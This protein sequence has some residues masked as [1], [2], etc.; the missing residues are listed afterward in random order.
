M[1][2]RPR[3]F[4]SLQITEY[5]NVPR[6]AQPIWSFCGSPAALSDQCSA[7]LG[8]IAVMVIDS[9]YAGLRVVEYFRY[10]QPAEAYLHF[11]AT[12]QEAA[13]RSVARLAV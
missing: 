1:R 6:S 10:Y 13:T 11:S 7:L 5:F 3:S 12:T 9:G 4:E 2:L 8:V